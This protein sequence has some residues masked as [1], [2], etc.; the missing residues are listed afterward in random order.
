MQ[1]DC[2]FVRGNNHRFASSNAFLLD[3]DE[4]IIKENLNFER[5]K[6]VPQQTTDHFFLQGSFSCQPY[7]TTTWTS[8]SLVSRTVF[9]LSMASRTHTNLWCF[10]TYPRSCH[11]L[12]STLDAFVNKQGLIVKCVTVF[13]CPFFLGLRRCVRSKNP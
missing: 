12:T 6:L 4:T 10:C 1:R 5:N 8:A 2:P 3:H 9:P 11:Y 7:L 13:L